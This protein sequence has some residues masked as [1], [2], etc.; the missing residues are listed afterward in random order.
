LRGNRFAQLVR[1]DGIE[2]PLTVLSGVGAQLSNRATNVGLAASMSQPSSMRDVEYRQ[3]GEG[4]GCDPEYAMRCQPG[5]QYE[6]H[7]DSKAAKLIHD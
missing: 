1:I 3:P 6:D 4:I 7:G 5:K 2:N